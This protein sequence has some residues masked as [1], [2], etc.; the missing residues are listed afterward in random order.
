MVGDWIVADKVG[1]GSQGVV[2][3][4]LHADRLDLHTYYALKLARDPLDRRFEREMHLIA[5]I[6][7]PCVARYEGHGYWKSPGGTVYPYLVMKWVEGVPLYDWVAVHGLTL[8]QAMVLVA[9]VARALE[10]THE[11]GLHRDVKGDNVLVSPEGRVVLV[12]YGCCWFPFAQPLTDPPIPPGTEQYRSP[13]L[14]RSKSR[15][16][17]KLTSYYEFQQADDVYALGVT[18][19][20]LVAC[21]YPPQL[22]ED[23]AGRLRPVQVSAPRG[24]EEVCPEFS[25]LIL[26]MLSEE[27]E[28]RGSAGGIAEALERLAKQE[29][30]ALD[31]PWV[32]RSSLQPTEKAERPGPPRFYQL[33]KWAPRL[34]LAVSPALVVLLALVLTRRGHEREVASAEPL[35]ALQGGEKPNAG[36]QGMGPE[37]LS[38]VAPSEAISG[39]ERTITRE[40]PDRP[41]DWQLR[42]PCDQRRGIVAINGGCW[43][44]VGGEQLPC[45]SHEY[46]YKG[47][48]YWPITAST[49]KRQKTS[50]DPP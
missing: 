6:H 15:F 17:R 18:A 31:E 20:R 44:P 34:A 12:D 32:K 24:L 38:S 46:E 1:S 10:A 16:Q 19:Y 43:S 11:H 37:A 5:R 30:L 27:P 7:H 23:D 33:K 22:S 9:Q 28:A 41:F 3:R 14:L 8:R 13:Q 48:C 45:Q 50:E 36:T 29:N 42:P 49:G 35:N 39:S 2:F 25:A 4:A 47:R 40:V 21:K 26:R